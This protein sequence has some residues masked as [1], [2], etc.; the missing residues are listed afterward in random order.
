MSVKTFLEAYTSSYTSYA[1]NP[2]RTTF[3]LRLL[4]FFL[5]EVFPKA[6]RG[7]KLL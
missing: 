3:S 7:P 2:R 4:L 6:H 5:T 1:V